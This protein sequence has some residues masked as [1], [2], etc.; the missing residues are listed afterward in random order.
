MKAPYELIHSVLDVYR[1]LPIKLARM[2]NKSDTWWRSHGYEPRSA[3][4]LSNGNPSAVD[5]YMAFVERY[6]AGEPGAG[7]MLNH[8]VHA[9][10]DERFSEADLL[11][12]TQS[13]LQVKI[14]EEECD[15]QKW[16]SRFD[17]ETASRNELLGFEKE[18][19]EAVEAIMAAK[20]R[21]RVIRVKN[22]VER[23]NGMKA[24]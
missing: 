7:A 24:I 22:A 14:I 9:E 17:L 2:T 3:N 18:C 23:T 5:Q 19:D 21:A 10:L 12:T 4:P 13:D 8:R 11:T 6:Q 20:A 1:A 16:L 15:I